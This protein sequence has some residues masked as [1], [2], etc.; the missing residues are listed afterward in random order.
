MK[1]RFAIVEAQGQAHI[2]G[3]STANTDMNTNTNTSITTTTATCTTAATTTVP[4]PQKRMFM[5]VHPFGLILVP[6][7]GFRTP[8]IG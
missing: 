8:R 6:A 3:C 2:G 4:N 7:G 1:T 5:V